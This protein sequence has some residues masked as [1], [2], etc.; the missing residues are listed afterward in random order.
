MNENKYFNVNQSLGLGNSS[1]IDSMNQLNKT[2]LSSRDQTVFNSV[3]QNYASNCI[4][5]DINYQNAKNRTNN[6]INN[7]NNANM[8]LGA[9][10]S[11]G[12][13]IPFDIIGNTVGDLNE[14]F[15]N[16]SDTHKYI[17]STTGI[18]S[19]ALCAGNLVLPGNP[20]SVAGCYAT[21]ALIA[22]E[23][24]ELKYH[25]AHITDPFTGKVNPQ[26]R[27]DYI[28]KNNPSPS[29]SYQPVPVY[30]VPGCNVNSTKIDTMNALLE[31]MKKGK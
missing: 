18:A 13:S 20:V 12:T 15:S 16:R 5:N 28:K 23:L 8:V 4:L 11:G 6:N 25:A 29:P 7:I 1:I 31:H 26:M 22:S 9:V 3:N 10:T 2:S 27:E 21:G 30:Q 24:V 19:T 17:R 14:Q